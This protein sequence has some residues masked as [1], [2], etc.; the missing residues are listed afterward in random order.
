MAKITVELD[1]NEDEEVIELLQ[2]LIALL[3]DAK[4]TK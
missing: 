3:E 2:R 4:R 1:T